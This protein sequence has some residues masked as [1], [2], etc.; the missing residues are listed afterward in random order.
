[1][2]TVV[3]DTVQPPAAV[4]DTGRPEDAVAAIVKSGLPNVLPASGPKSIVWIAFAIVN[5]CVTSSAGLKFSFPPCDAMIAH[6]PAPVIRTLAGAIADVRVHGPD[7][8]S[9]TVRPAVDE[10]SISKSESPYVASPIVVN[11]IV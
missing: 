2:C 5:E 6:V 10:A 9:A 4:N 7:A 11:V 3:P 8:P 1:M